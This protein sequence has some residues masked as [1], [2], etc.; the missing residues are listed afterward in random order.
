MKT[1]KASQTSVS[2]SAASI[3]ALLLLGALSGSALAATD[4]HEPCHEAADSADVLHTFIAGN[5]ISAPL[6]R[7]V[8][9]AESAVPARAAEAADDDDSEADEADTAPAADASTPAY[10]T[11]LPGVSANDMPG[12]RRHMYRTDI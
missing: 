7:T 9:T 4:I 3:P 5:D 12:F 10:T 6:L 1:A 11:R 2:R 8:D